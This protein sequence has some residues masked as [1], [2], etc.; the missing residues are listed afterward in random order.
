MATI[1]LQ[2]TADG[3]QFVRRLPLGSYVLGRESACNVVV[4]APGV[5]RRHARLTFS[6]THVEV[7][8]LGSSAGSFVGGARL[9]GPASF[10]LPAEVVLGDLPIRLYCGEAPPKF[11]SNSP[12]AA[13]AA[14][15]SAPQEEDLNIALSMSGAVRRKVPLGELNDKAK[16]RLEMLY[17]LPLQFAAESDLEKL[18]PLILDRVLAVTPG[19]VRG[20]LLIKDFNDGKLSVR[21]CVPSDAPPISRT[22]IRRAAV[23]QLG[24]IWGDGVADQG[25]FSASMAAIKVRTGMYV[26]LVWKGNTLGVLFLDNPHRQSAFESEDLQFLLSVA[27][28]AAAAV[29]N[30]MLQ[31][32]I[33]QNNRTLQNLLANFSPKIRDCL[34]QKSRGGKLQPGGLK[35]QVTVLFSDLRGFTRKS[36][37]MSTDAIVDMLNDYLWALGEEIFH[38]DGTIDKFI[39]DA[40]LAVF[41]SPEPDSLHAWKAVCAAIQMQHRMAEVNQRRRDAGLVVCEMGIGVHTGE[42]LHGFIGAEERLEYTVIG[43]TVNRTSRYCSGAGE[44]EVL[45]G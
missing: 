27:N 33:I 16:Q 31:S 43:D 5:S 20:A 9:S 39:G 44:G 28:Y 7:E 40:I 15:K 24:F 2:F 18:Y 30:Q 32:E 35:S 14:S 17:D 23:E 45:L 10:E 25:E 42:V 8:D 34:L 1:T 22:L 29:S 36:A 3:Q 21:A 13:P 11:P 38:H 37:T 6:A 4:A 12:P 19:A 26:P 41:G